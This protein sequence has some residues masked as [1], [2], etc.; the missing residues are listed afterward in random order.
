MRT[1]HRIIERMR[2]GAFDPGSNPKEYMRKVAERYK[3]WFGEE[4]DT[5]NAERFVQQLREKEVLDD[6]KMRG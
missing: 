6:L 3:I 5:S 1:A 2:A 4:L